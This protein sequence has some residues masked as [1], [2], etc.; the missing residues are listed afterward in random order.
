M[1]SNFWG[2]QIWG[3]PI[4]YPPRFTNRTF[5][6]NR[7][8]TRVRCNISR[9]WIRLAGFFFCSQDRPQVHCRLYLGD[10]TLTEDPSHPSPPTVS[11]PRLTR[12]K[13]YASR[14]ALYCNQSATPYAR[15][16]MGCSRECGETA[17][18]ALV[19]RRRGGCWVW[20]RRATR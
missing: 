4:L 14:A 10:T 1:V 3:L 6:M 5:L 16:Q 20:L 18:M 7:E 17:I 13:P 2:L 12:Y 9:V 11:S 15:E 19:M 8:A